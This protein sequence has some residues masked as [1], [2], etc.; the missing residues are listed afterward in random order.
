MAIHG[1][2]D[3]TGSCRRLLAEKEEAMAELFAILPEPDQRELLRLIGLV[4]E[5]LQN[6]ARAG[7]LRRPRS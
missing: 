1:R 3:A 7:S 6:S 2:H 5:A 4:H